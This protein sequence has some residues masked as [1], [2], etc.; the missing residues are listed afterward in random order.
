MQLTRILNVARWVII[1]QDVSEEGEVQGYEDNED[2]IED[3]N[4]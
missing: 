2:N 4:K 1:V 3:E